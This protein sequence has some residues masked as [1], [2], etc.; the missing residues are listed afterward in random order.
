[1]TTT[2]E[3]HVTVVLP[4][5]GS[6]PAAEPGSAALTSALPM[7]AG[8]GSMVMMAGMSGVGQARTFVAG[9]FFLLSTALVIATQVAR[10][11]R[12][13][14]RRVDEA[15]ATFV[16]ELDAA[17]TQLVAASHAHR[18]K[19][20]RDHPPLATWLA[21]PRPVSTPS[22][23]VRLGTWT[24]PTACDVVAPPPP[25]P[26][27]ADPF[28]VQAVHDLATHGVPVRGVPW[29]VDLA[30]WPEVV[31]Q[32]DD[33]DAARSRVRHLVC[34]AALGRPPEALTVVLSCPP[35]L[36]HHWEWLKW[37]PHHRH[38]DT[39]DVAAGRRLLLDSDT[40]ADPPGDGRAT[41]LLVDGD[42]ELPRGLPAAGTTVVRLPSAATPPCAPTPRRAVLR[43]GGEG[44]DTWTT[45]DGTTACRTEACS[46]GVAEL[47]ARRLDSLHDRPDHE[48]AVRLDDL[49]GMLGVDDVTTWSPTAW[50]ATRPATPTLRV[51]IGVDTDGLPVHL[52]LRE[53]A[54]GGDGPHGLVVGATGSGKSE[55]LRTLVLAL[56]MEHS[57]DDLGMVL[58]DFKGGA[59]FAGLGELPHV[60]AVVTNLGDD[61]AL[62][63][64]M[65]DTLTGELVRRQELLRSTGHASLL[66]HRRDRLRGADLEPLPSLFV[67]I[68]E[69]SEL[70]SARPD[71]IDV[72]V[73]IGRVGRSLGVHLLLASQR[74]EEGRLRGLETHLSYRIGLR[75]FSAAESRA[76]IGRPDA[77]TLPAVPGAGYLAT[78]AGDPVRFTA[79]YVSGPPPSRTSSAPVHR[80]PLP[81]TLRPIP[82]PPSLAR[83]AAPGPLPSTLTN[84]GTTTVDLVVAR[85]RGLARTR[86]VWLP[87][88][89]T[90]ETVG[91]LFGDLT[92]DSG[93]GVHSP[94]WRDAP[95]RRVP[96]GIVDRPREQRRDVWSLDLS[97][98]TGHCVVVG[99]PHSGR[100]T[101]LQTLVTGLALTATPREVQFL[102]LDH[103]GGGLAPLAGLPHVVASAARGEPLLARVVAEATALVDRREALFRSE[104]IDSFGSYLARRAEGD[105]D[106]G[107]GEV[108]VVVDGWG[109]LRA[110]DLETESALHRLAE[111]SLAFGVH[112]VVATQ[113]WSDLRPAL[114]DQFGSQVEL[115][116]G[117][118]MDSTI[119]RRRAATVPLA[120][121]H[122]LVAGGH[123]LLTALPGLAL[124]GLALAGAVGPGPA[125]PPDVPGPPELLADLVATVDGGWTGRR[126]RR[127]APL[128]ERVEL[129]E[130]RGAGAPGHVLLG[131]DGDGALALPAQAGRHLLVRGGPGTGRTTVLRTYV[132]ELQ[133]L[134]AP[135]AMQ[136]VLVDPR[137][138]LEGAVGAEHLLHHLVGRAQMRARLGELASYLQGRLPG[139]DVTAEELRARSWWRGAE[140]TVVVDD[141]DLATAGGW[142]DCGLHLLAPL[143]PQAREVGLQVVVAQRA[144]ARAADPLL[145]ALVDLDVPRLDLTAATVPGRARLTVRGEASRDLQTALPL[146]AVRT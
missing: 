21:A 119:D 68:D 9:G 123:A 88:L 70:L 4:A 113:R 41:L 12:Q 103:G 15:R 140:V 6:L 81:W 46:T 18:R 90:P 80:R 73:A 8:L 92:H 142:Q 3:D 5:P 1:M 42:A 79:A 78:G 77:H 65:A 102:L 120:P 64:R 54:Q 10:Q 133:R 61:L 105:V 141:H 98:A 44:G 35:E 52:D 95:G 144:S 107:Y 57:P 16:R 29:T 135:A 45:T 27:R 51:P 115:R 83:Q 86:P 43:V 139:P 63:D 94:R 28:A 108:F 74:I 2:V 47:V 36:E 128:P 109:V 67:C 71:F 87:P 24:L 84:T 66:E 100:T 132:Q 125:G 136:L 104:G 114:R 122:G 93:L 31:V 89:T 32:G 55:L 48:D 60:S 85:T 13:H 137:G 130:L 20:E 111:R 116:L 22:T 121:G 91:T 38:P 40:V 138:G 19:L 146:S 49:P 30:A 129:H 82:D 62:V 134:H 58:V 50:W 117:D 11:R 25:E 14:Q 143:L 72:F 37:L 76:A 97:G 23:Q 7:L 106:D 59:T 112:L 127:L 39:H 126:P 124:P 75:T 69:F 56:A 96:V 17:R 131:H 99:G 34:H 110:D 26:E 33:T 145:Q 53:S 118:P 101:V